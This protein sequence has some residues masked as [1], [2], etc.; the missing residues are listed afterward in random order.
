MIPPTR[1]E[2]AGTRHV[3]AAGHFLAAAAAHDVLV[4]GG[5]A[6]DAGCAAGIALGV[7]QPD[8]VNVAGVAPIMIRMAGMETPITIDGLGT[9]S[10]S[11]P[12]RHFMER[13][14]G[15]IPPGVERIVVPAAPA[16]WIEALARYGTMS[17]REVAGA[18]ARFAREGF[19]VHPL[20]AETIAEYEEGY[21]AWPAN[22]AIYLPRGRPPRVGERFVQ[23]DLADTFERLFR[24]EEGSSGDRAAGL[25]A[26]RA[27]FYEGEIAREIV[28]YVAREGGFLSREDMASYRCRIEPALAMRTLGGTL[29]VCGAWCQGPVLP[30]TLAQIEVLGLDGLAHNDAD[31]IHL[32]VE[33][34]KGAFA[35]R[36]HHFGDPAFVDV[37]L[38]ALVSPEHARARAAE[39]DRRRA[40]QEMP[41]PLLPL[42]STGE[43]TVPAGGPDPRPEPDTSYVAVVDRDGNAFSATPSDGSWNVPVV[44]GTGLVPSS[45]GSQSRPDPAHPSGA[46]AGRRPRLTPNPA[47]FVRG[48]DVMPFGT[49]GGDVQSQAM[50][51]L[52]LNRYH[53]GMALQEAIDAPRFA[54]YDFPGSFAPFTHHHGLVKLEPGIP[55]RVGEALA[56]RGHT[57]SY[58]R[59]RD[60]RAGGLCAVETD[61]DEGLIRGGADPRRPAYAIG[62]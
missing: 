5:N 20:L 44:P 54:T 35:D 18:A 56:A 31:Y 7:L 11:L 19:A 8:L 10:R 21:R 50:L 1:P 59:E 26:V 60:W 9:W 15:T 13:H 41:G 12:P 33:A 36:E 58:W 40:R 57:V 34:M 45:R 14:G 47:L 22:A 42:G 49:P 27:A 29:H 43:R 4:A 46:A 55:E 23:S 53:F 28:D 3:V 32:L 51:Q 61:R 30:M 25:A 52:L 39:I 17:F 24:A 37:P 38:D 2:I 6:V 48:D 62:L 16:A